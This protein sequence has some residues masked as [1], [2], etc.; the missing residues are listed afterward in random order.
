MFLV[1][2]IAD[3]LVQCFAVLLLW[4]AASDLHSFSIPNR[5]S[6]AMCLLYPAYVLASPV[7]VE[8]LPACG[9][10]LLTFGGGA[11]AFSRGWFG[12]GDVKL[13]AAAA[14]WAGPAQFSL[15]LFV[16]GLAG[17]VL[18]LAVLAQ[19]R[20]APF[21]AQLRLSWLPEIPSCS[22]VSA[23]NVAGGGSTL[24]SAARTNIPYGV[25]IAAGGLYVAI[26]LLAN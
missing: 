17:G 26:Q 24:G 4:A 9:L 13:L 5:I 16:T 7:P 3:G 6:A 14:L 19:P 22:G 12:G 23:G 15:L 8:W 21:L 20:I 25:A 18:S 2:P 11:F 1:S 10:A